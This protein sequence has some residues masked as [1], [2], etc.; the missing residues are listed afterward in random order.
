MQENNVAQEIHLTTHT[1]QWSY[2][3][4]VYVARSMTFYALPESELRSITFMNTL[5]LVSCSV[6][7]FLLSLG[8]GIVIGGVFSSDISPTAEALMKVVAPILGVLAVVSYS[9]GA[10]ALILRKKAIK[11]IRD[12]S[13]VIN[14]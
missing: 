8:L 7:S 5:A 3:Q 1:A 2:V 4:P 11:T 12:D 14:Q 9:V 6:G 13:R 10:W